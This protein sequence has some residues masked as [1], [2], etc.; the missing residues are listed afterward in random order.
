MVGWI[1]M[2]AQP[3]SH[4]IG[5]RTGILASGEASDWPDTYAQPPRHLIG[6][7]TEY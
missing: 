2:Y 3:P 6:Q 1:N 5:Q 7:G 4:L